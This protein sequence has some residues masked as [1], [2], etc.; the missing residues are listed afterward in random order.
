MRAILGA[1][2]AM[3]RCTQQTRILISSLQSSEPMKKPVS[4]RLLSDMQQI[5]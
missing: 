1:Q 5:A 4:T 2:R 3:G